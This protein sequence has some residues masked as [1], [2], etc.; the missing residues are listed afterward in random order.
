MVFVRPLF[1]LSFAFTG[2]Q[3]VQVPCPFGVGVVGDGT[4]QPRRPAMTGVDVNWTP[5]LFKVECFLPKHSEQL[6]RY[7][8]R[9]HFF[10]ILAGFAMKIGRNH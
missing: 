10:G 7:I 9:C 2:L 1:W 4:G 8:C 6:S 3:T 5:K